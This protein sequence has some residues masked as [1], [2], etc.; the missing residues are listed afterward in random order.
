M[1]NRFKYTKPTVLS[2]VGAGLR[3]LALSKN[4]IIKCKGF[5]N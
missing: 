5:N 3:W 1:L 2:A 4:F